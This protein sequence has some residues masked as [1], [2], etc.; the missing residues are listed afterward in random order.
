MS[1]R[2]SASSLEYCP[3]RVAVDM[4]FSP[5]LCLTEKNPRIPAR[6]THVSLVPLHSSVAALRRCL[7]R[8]LEDG[9][10]FHDAPLRR[11]NPRGDGDRFVEIL[12]FNQVVAAELLTRLRVRTVRDEP[13][14]VTLTDT[15]GH[16]RRLQ[17]VTGHIVAARLDL[18][19][20]LH[21]HLH[22]LLPLAL[23]KLLPD[24]G[25]VVN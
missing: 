3:F 7:R 13:F 10:H 25:V 12:G 19:R 8:P 22:A 1:A 5:L 6:M 16:G 9:P 23:T 24:F 4:I 20:K 11:R 21:V 17:L 18:L 14:A 15:S 2:I